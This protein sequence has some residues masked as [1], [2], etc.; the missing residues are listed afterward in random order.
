L[1][2]T[3]FKT[4][5]LE[6]GLPVLVDFWAAWCSPCKIIA[7]VIEELAREYKDKIKIGKL[8]V[9]TNPKTATDYGIMSIPTLIF[10]KH[11]KVTEQLAGVLNKVELKRKIEESL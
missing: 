9:D 11:G 1:T 3:N 8:D 10:F 4:E 6:S 2:D 7:P 5:V